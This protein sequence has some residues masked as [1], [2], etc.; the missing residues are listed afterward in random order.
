MR[1]YLLP[2]SL[3]VLSFG[4]LLPGML[5]YL[6]QSGDA[7]SRITPDKSVTPT[8]KLQVQSAEPSPRTFDEKEALRISQAAIGNQ[9]G[10]YSF[11]DRSGRTVRISDYRG[12]PLVISMIYTH[13]PIICATTTRSLS[14]LKLSQ[15]A[16]GT[17]SFGVLTVGFDTE[18]DTPEAMGDFAKRMDVN[19]SNWE[20][21]SADRDTVKKLSKDLGFVFFPADEGGF[22]HITQT[23]FVDGR[24]KVYL[25]IYGEEFDNKTLLQPLKDLVYNIKTAEPGLVGLSNKVR[26]FCTV[27]DTKTGNYRVDYGYFYGIGMGFIVSFFIIWWIWYEHRRSP[28]RNRPGDV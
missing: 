11:K 7:A 1:R 8:V 20:F 28:K 17:D 6:A 14:A 5:F 25:H 19:L 3:A 12:K 21:V 24:G 16:L 27:Y 10:D 22:N 4:V 23:T 26:L 15:A 9:L 13:C 2:V 18:S